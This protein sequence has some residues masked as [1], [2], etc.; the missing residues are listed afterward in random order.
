[1]MK[2]PIIIDTDPGID[3]AIAIAIATASDALDVKLITT[4]A[5]NV[6]LSKVTNN[7]LKLLALFKNEIPVAKGAKQPLL[8]APVDASEVHGET[9]MDGYDFPKQADHLLMKED[10]VTAMYQLLSKA[11]EPLIIVAIGPLTNI[12][13]LLRTHPEVSSKIAEIVLMGGALGR[14]NKG[15]LAEFNIVVDPEA[16]RIVFESGLPIVMAPLDVGLK[17]LVY[18][19]DSEEI[20]QMNA[21]GEMIY[22]ILQRYRNVQAVNG[23]AMYDACAIAYLLVPEIYQTVDAYVAIETQG[24]YTAGAT[25]VDLAGSMGKTPNAKV[26]VDID[27]TLFKKWLMESLRKC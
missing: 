22:H 3:D 4:V 11:E 26:C 14:G 16:A 24:E 18:A 21:T 13:L 20:R 7:A 2:R 27:S 1:M 12:A 6:S 23:S 10:A 17:A 9:G 19:S 8:R 25:V 5:G 15:I